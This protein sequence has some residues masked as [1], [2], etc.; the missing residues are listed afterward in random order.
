VRTD[1]TLWCWG[2]NAAG[3]LGLG[4]TT[5]QTSPTQVGSATTWSAASA[6][7]K[8]TCA[9]RTDGSVWCWGDNSYGQLGLGDST[10]R[11]SPVQ[12]PSVTAGRLVCGALSDS[13]FVLT[14]Q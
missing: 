4:S 5:G 12:V 10:R 14:T 11:T 3:Q 6:G 7:H 2:D 9:L 8:H 1:G 13:T